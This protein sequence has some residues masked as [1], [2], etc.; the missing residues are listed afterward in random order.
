MTVLL[1]RLAAPLQ[2]WGDH[3]RFRHRDTSRQPTK[4]GVLGLLAAACGRRRTDPIEDLLS[5]RFGVRVDQPGVVLRDFHTAH[6]NGPAKPPVVTEREYLSDAVFVAGLEGNDQLVEGLA[7]CLEHPR[8]PLYLGRRSCPVEGELVLGT[9]GDPLVQALEAVPWQAAAHHRRRQS[10]AVTLRMVV[11]APVGAQVVSQAHDEPVSFD[12]RQRAHTWRSV[13]ERSVV[14]EN[15]DGRVSDGG[16][17]DWF[18][19]LGA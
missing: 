11:D 16:L 6:V 8:F 4:S 19:G 13:E 18:S 5:L 9:S 1:L 2:A 14:V 12:P 3:S 15:P 7:E 17:L 10:T